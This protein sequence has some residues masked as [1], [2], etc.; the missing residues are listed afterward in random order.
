[1]DSNTFIYDVSFPD[2]DITYPVS[3]VNT[4]PTL[5]GTCFDSSPGI[6]NTV[7]V[8][9]RRQDNKYWHEDTS[10]W[11][12]ASE[13][14]NIANLSPSAT[15]WWWQDDTIWGSNVEYNVNSWAV[16]NAGNYEQSFSTVT[17]KYDADAPQ[18]NVEVPISGNYYRNLLTL[19]GTGTGY[20]SDVDKSCRYY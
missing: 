7:Y 17:F 1:V 13:Y 20:S 3:D 14:W 6:V 5:K 11:I 2:S 10:E 4:K 19:S 18:S 9:I 8:R 15:F 16:D 12:L